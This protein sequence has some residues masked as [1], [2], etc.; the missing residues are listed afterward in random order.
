MYSKTN[1]GPKFEPLLFVEHGLKNGFNNG[2]NPCHYFF[3]FGKNLFVMN[4]CRFNGV[5]L[6]GEIEPFQTLFAKLSVIC[7]YKYFPHLLFVTCC[8]FLIFFKCHEKMQFVKL[9]KIQSDVAKNTAQS[10]TR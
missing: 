1:N 6:I 7:C 5:S 2:L 4:L 8:R 3:K 10:L 9:H